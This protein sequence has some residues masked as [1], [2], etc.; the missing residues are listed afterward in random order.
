MN[1][2]FNQGVGCGLAV[3]GFSTLHPRI[4]SIKLSLERVW[5]V[6]GVGLQVTLYKDL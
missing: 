4:T 6:V 5:S 3:S 1:I 2:T